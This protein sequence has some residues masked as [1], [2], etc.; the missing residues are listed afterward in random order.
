MDGKR[1]GYVYP[2]RYSS[3]RTEEAFVTDRLPTALRSEPIVDV[4]CEVRFE[5]DSTDAV[6]LLPG[7]LSSALGDFDRVE[8]SPISDFPSELHLSEE[9]KFQ[10]H[11]R[12]FNGHRVVAI[13]PGVLA[14]STLPPYGGWRDFSDYALK[15]IR[16]LE[17][18]R[19]VGRMSRISLRYTDILA[20][21]GAPRMEWL[22]AHLRIGNAT[23]FST[24]N[25]RAQREEAGITVIHQIAGPA[26]TIDGR[27]G[28]VVDV[29]TIA[30]APSDF[31]ESLPA[32]F[33]ELHAVN[34]RAFFELLTNETLDRLGPEY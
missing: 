8:R 33:N 1:L 20:F 18:R 13:G 12:L 28:M 22:N 14:A 27:V 31:W 26:R 29:D 9:L 34:K 21:E 11:V 10:P 4:V 7:M 23:T 25:V 15:V 3:E 5:T 16:A 30:P 19:F 17:G 24:F 6:S 32:A 2:V